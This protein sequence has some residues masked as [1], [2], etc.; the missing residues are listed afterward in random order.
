MAQKVTVALAAYDQNNQKL[1]GTEIEF[2]IDQSEL[3]L[4]A[5]P[6][7]YTWPEGTMYLGF[8][9]IEYSQMLIKIVPTNPEEEFDP[10]VGA[11]LPKG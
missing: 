7:G 8:W 2:Q 10:H 6:E 1:P 5:V 4:L 3:P 11:P 9:L